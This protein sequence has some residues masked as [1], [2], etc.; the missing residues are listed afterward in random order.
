MGSFGIDGLG[1][2]SG[3]DVQGTVSQILLLEAAPIRLMQQQQG[4]LDAQA[5]ALTVINRK[6]NTLSSRIDSLADLSGTFNSKSVT[7]SHSDLLTA[8]ATSLALVASH[9]IQIT[10]LA[11]TSVAVINETFD[12]GE[13]DIGSTGKFTIQVGSGTAFEVVVNADNSTLD[14]IAETINNLDEDVSAS[15]IIDANGA[16]L[17]LTSKST[18]LDGDLTITQDGTDP[19]ETI[20][21]TVTAATN[22]TFTVNSIS[23]ESSSN[24]VNDVIPGVT[25]TLIGAS[26]GTDIALNIRQDTARAKAA[27]Q[28]FVTAF[29]SL[30]SDINSQSGVDENGA[31]PGVV[32]SGDASLRLIQGSIFRDLNFSLTDNNGIES[33]VALGITMGE[34]GTL[35][36]DNSALDT[37]LKSNFEDVQAFIQAFADNFKTDLDNL[38]DTTDGIVNLAL[39]NLS[40]SR[41]SIQVSIESFEVR[42]LV[43]RE[44]LIREFSLIDT[45]IRRLPLIRSQIEQQL[46]TLPSTFSSSR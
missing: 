10:T 32:L 28:S 5:A 43:R 40:T 42:L 41:D 27:I 9:I 39:K 6:L 33:I 17:S 11:T 31:L 29:N 35:S 25:L 36:V 8:S 46:S 23:V 1:L 7:S 37:A 34:D 18:G 38:T 44:A 22:A 15:V 13:T 3:I 26:P 45:L 24:T 30:S 19:V 16:R 2:G 20:S 4:R 21:F 14:G 12:D